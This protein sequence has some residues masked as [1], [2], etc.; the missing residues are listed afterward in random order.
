M[1]LPLLLQVSSY[2]GYCLSFSSSCPMCHLLSTPLPLLW[3][4]LAPCHTP[5]HW[6]TSCVPRRVPRA[7]WVPRWSPPCQC[8]AETGSPVGRATH[9]LPNNACLSTQ[10]S[11]PSP[12]VHVGRPLK[13]LC[14]RTSNCK[15]GKH[16]RAFGFPSYQTLC[17]PFPLRVTP[18]EGQDV[19][20]HHSS[21]C[22]LSCL[23]C[24]PQ[25]FM[26]RQSSLKS[27]VSKL[28]QGG[29]NPGP[30]LLFYGPRDK[31]YFFK[32]FF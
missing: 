20:L 30:A 11:T 23:L 29:P 3:G 8:G 27:G 18:K 1:K 7:A 19:L 12:P 14:S 31:E 5:P 2:K 15:Q 16:P 32:I 24:L 13:L 17:C 22:F 4:H 25:V 28:A 9:L 10:P 21:S 6:V 26:G